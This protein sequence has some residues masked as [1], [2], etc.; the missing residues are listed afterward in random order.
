MRRWL[1][2]VFR[3][4]LKELASFAADKVLFAFIV[5][6]FSFAVYSMA[7]GGLSTDVKNASVAIVD[8]DRSTLSLR[9]REALLR[10]Y[11]REARVIDRAELDAAMDA[12]LYSF[13]LDLPPNLEADVLRGREPAIQI[14]IDA[15]AMSQAG[16]GG[17]YIG[18][19][20]QQEI[21][22]W[23]QSRGLGETM[24][25][26]TATRVFFNQNLDVVRF[27]AVMGVI[28][29]ITILTMF[30]IGAAIMREREHGTIEHLL[31]MPVRASEIALAK[32]W[33]N[34]LLILLAAGLSLQFIVQ[35]VLRV[36][37]EGSVAL[38]LAGTGVY[39]F[40]ITSLGIMLAT[41][42]RSMPQFALLAMPVFL[43]LNMLSGAVS[44]L[45]AMPYAL[46][47]VDQASPTV[48]FVKLAQSVLYRAAGI[49][50]I[51]PHLLVLSGLG[52]AFLL[53]AL[54]RFRTMLARAQQ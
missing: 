38:F 17:A 43:V 29:Q 52:A 15:T 16:I 54:A 34:G 27:Q 18:A 44:P 7:T 23:M 3:L 4:G 14:N 28:Q 20:L 40:A 48:H 33:A 6:S 5:Y 9:I 12:G 10:P 46:Q 31:V 11:F 19:I 2:N 42:V 50:V 41:L 30:L 13:V 22:T 32:I 35:G 51:W 47:V 25:V 1:A 53:V 8:N 36:P 37:I 39:L 24:P 45:E 21:A 49:D 26:A